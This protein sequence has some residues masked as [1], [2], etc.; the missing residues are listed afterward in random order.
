[1]ATRSRAVQAALAAF[2]LVLVVGV[3]AMG[4]ATWNYTQ[5]SNDFCIGCHVMNPAFAK[6][7]S[8]ENKHAEL[9][10]HDCHQQPIS[11][12]VRQLYLWVKERPQEIGEHAKVPN[13][14]CANCHVTG[15]TVRWQRVAA[16]AGHR[17]HPE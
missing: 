5:H 15:D 13:Q 1:M 10:C 11:A 17:V 6:F 16:P 7:S 3:G 14:V 9:S 12:S 2:A 8:G 4:A